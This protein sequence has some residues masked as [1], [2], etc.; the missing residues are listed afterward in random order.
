M[1]IL[2][3]LFHINYDEYQCESQFSRL[4]RDIIV[5]LE[6]YGYC[7]LRDDGVRE[8]VIP[9]QFNSLPRDARI[10]IQKSDGTTLYITR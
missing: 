5:E 9:S 3:Q 7:H 10:V 6:Q 4:S 1:I 8:A 2:L